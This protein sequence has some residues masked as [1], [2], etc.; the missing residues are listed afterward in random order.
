MGIFPQETRDYEI[1]ASHNGFISIQW[2][3]WIPRKTPLVL[4]FNTSEQWLGGDSVAK[5]PR[6]RLLKRLENPRK[7]RATAKQLVAYRNSTRGWPRCDGR[8]VPGECFIV[9]VRQL[10]IA[11]RRSRAHSCGSDDTPETSWKHLSPPAP[12]DFD[13]R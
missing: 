13:P 8:T 11:V 7:Q 6:I 3:Q 9:E 5:N 12:F 1:F 2:I 4:R 10:R